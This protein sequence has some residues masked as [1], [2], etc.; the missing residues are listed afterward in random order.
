[1]LLDKKFEI[2]YDYSLDVPEE[3]LEENNSLIKMASN[4]HPIVTSALEIAKGEIGVREIGNTNTGK[5]V[6]EYQASTTLDG[7]GWSWCS[8]FCCW[9]VKQAAIKHGQNSKTFWLPSAS[10]DYMLYWARKNNILYNSPQV[11]DAFLV[12]ATQNDATHIGLVRGVGN[13]TFT[14]VEGNTNNDKSS[15]GIGVFSLTRPR[16]S[17]YRFI[18][19]CE[20]ISDEQT[21][22][23]Y[24]NDR[25]L[26]DA[27]LEG[28]VA[29]IPVRDWARVL[30]FT[31][32]WNQATQT[33][34][35]NGRVVPHQVSMKDNKAWLPLK[36]LA[37]FSAL[38][39]TM[40]DDKFVVTK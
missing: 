26:F 16:T 27:V 6:Q 12:M 36:L 15:N 17:R 34:L 29:R 14:T 20:L 37:D 23:V 3:G 9:C 18:R 38:K 33:I 5:R 31:V 7:T 4:Q 8:A 30:G 24:L 35:L 28:G 2:K 1:M 25:Y 21:R 11:G 32:G 22:K 39:I 13:D 10:C 19:W 40:F